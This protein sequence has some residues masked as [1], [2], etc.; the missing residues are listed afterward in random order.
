[1][2]RKPK[3]K[4]VG[5]APPPAIQPGSSAIE[6]TLAHYRAA[7]ASYQSRGSTATIANDVVYWELKDGQLDRPIIE[8]CKLSELITAIK[9]AEDA[10]ATLNALIC[11]ELE[12][13]ELGK[14]FE[15]SDWLAIRM[16]E[17]GRIAAEIEIE[18]I[19]LDKL[20]ADR[21]RLQNDLK[22]HIL[23]LA[24]AEAHL[25][26]NRNQL[27]AALVDRAAKKATDTGHTRFLTLENQQKAI[28]N[29]LST[30]PLTF[31]K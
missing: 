8:E 21:W 2:A 17:L 6:A 7:V 13:H 14:M 11:T 25:H 9:F 5:D 22:A 24:K 4:R 27:A 23:D 30:I 12:P 10:S 15:A 18:E 29:W 20:I 1:M 16:H 3:L 19:K 28:Y 26:P 31:R